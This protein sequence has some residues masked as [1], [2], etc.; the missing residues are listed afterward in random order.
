[1]RN[2]QFEVSSLEQSLTTLLSDEQKGQIMDLRLMMLRFILSSD[3]NVSKAEANLKSYIEW[4]FKSDDG[5]AV[6]TCIQSSRYPHGWET[7][8]KFSAVG[9]HGQSLDGD[10]L[11]VIRA[12]LSNGK[13][14]MSALTHD[15]LVH[16]MIFNRARMM[17]ICD[18]E[19]LKTG[20]LTKFITIN[21]LAHTS[22]SKISGP[23]NS[24]LTATA[25]LSEVYFPQ[26]LDSA[27]LI[28]MPRS[29]LVLFSTFKRLLPQK[30]Q[31]KIRV[32]GAVKDGSIS[33]CP[34]AKLHL[35]TSSVPSFLG[36][37]CRCPHKGGC[38][39]GI[40]NDQKVANLDSEDGLTAWTISR[41]KKY[42]IF[43]PV[44]EPG[45]TL[46]WQVQV[47]PGTISS[48]SVVLEACLRDLT[49]EVLS[50]LIDKKEVKPGQ[51]VISGEVVV[52]LAPGTIVFALTNTSS[53]WSR[54][55]KYRVDLITSRGDL[56]EGRTD[57]ETE[58]QAEGSHE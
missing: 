56:I 23:F 38:I 19:T 40:D 24:V 57:E 10:F 35:A 30:V 6:Y 5:R 49:S 39:E 36:G 8:Q 15:Q 34:W 51:G 28:N 25:K 9:F 14:L 47:D 22:L 44:K 46:V 37:E 20:R 53:I 45:S 42:E 26:L 21:D 55:V 50:T 54:S 2:H 48:G 29:L 18:E 3:G 7:M 41:G 43:V 12:G 13:A 17:E 58:R 31:S 11:F 4:R 33:K 1:M 52:P 27:V 32:C 16:I